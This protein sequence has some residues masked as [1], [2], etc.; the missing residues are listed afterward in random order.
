MNNKYDIRIW[1][2]NEYAVY[3]KD[4]PYD[5]VFKGTLEQINAWISLEEKGFEIN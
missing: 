2:E 4:D 3:L 5:Y 1:Q